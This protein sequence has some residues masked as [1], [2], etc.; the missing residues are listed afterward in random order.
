MSRLGS[1]LL[2]DISYTLSGKMVPEVSS[3]SNQAKLRKAPELVR[4]HISFK[5]A[6][7]MPFG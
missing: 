4:W 6:I 2:I 3:K 1:S 7:L 5:T